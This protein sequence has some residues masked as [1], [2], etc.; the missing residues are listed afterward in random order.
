M[1]I[2]HE[3]N[4]FGF[5]SDTDWF[6]SALEEFLHE[7]GR[8]AAAHPERRPWHWVDATAVE[9][10]LDAAWDML[11]KW[12]ARRAVQVDQSAFVRLVPAPIQ[13]L[14]SV[15]NRHEVDCLRTLSE[16]E[17]MVR[18]AVSRAVFRT[19]EEI[20]R[21]K[22]TKV[23]APMFGSKVAH[24]Y[25]PSIVPVFDDAK[26]RK[27]LMCSSTW[28]RTM[29]DSARVW[30][31]HVDRAGPCDPAMV[32]FQQ[33]FAFCATQIEEAPGQQLWAAREALSTRCGRF[34]PPMLRTDQKSLLWRLDAK[35]AEFCG[36]GVANSE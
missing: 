31:R 1:N 21:I 17:G 23:L 12:Q 2:I 15:L 35:I 7:H 13:R 16:H 14:A 18:E 26:I 34:A 27:M 30:R 28:D 8:Q 22:P 11:G 19:V 25:F 6:G 10:C 9:A 32:D 33:Y 24:H 3:T 4:L 5:F 36:C 20:S 29:Q